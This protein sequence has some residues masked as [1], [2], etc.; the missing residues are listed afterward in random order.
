MPRTPRFCDQLHDVAVLQHD[1]VC[2]NLGCRAAE[3]HDRSFIVPYAGVVQDDHVGQNAV[4]AL[5]MVWRWPHLRDDAGIWAQ[6]GHK[7]SHTLKPQ[8]AF[9]KR[10]TK[11]P[12]AGP[13]LSPAQAVRIRNDSYVLLN[14]TDAR[15]LARCHGAGCRWSR[16]HARRG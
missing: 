12:T 3:L 10:Q 4:L 7:H 2:G 6:L 16:C 5:A 15:L 1:I 13:A 9:A 11:T 8:D 14:A